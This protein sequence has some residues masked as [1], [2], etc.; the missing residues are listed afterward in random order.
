MPSFICYRCASIYFPQ[1]INA[2]TKKILLPQKI[3]K[4]RA[5]TEH[6]QVYGEKHTE[7]P[8]LIT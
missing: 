6:Q 8:G 5:V 7:W 3:K 1:H 2:I 4:I